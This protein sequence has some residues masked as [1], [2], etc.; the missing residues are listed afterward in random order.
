MKVSE[1][2]FKEVM[3]QTAS[4]VVVI[5]T[6][7]AGEMYGFTANSFTSLSLSPALVLFC[8]NNKS[9]SIDALR[10]SRKFGVSILS[11]EQEE[12]SRRFAGHNIDKFADIDYY[13]GIE[14][15]CPLIVNSVGSIECTIENEYDGGDHTIFIGLAREAT[16]NNDLDPIIYHSGAYKRIAK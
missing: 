3:R 14:T 16:V 2:K 8:I 15:G 9:R 12:I 13:N 10:K 7:D 11:C 1:A 6:I 4:G 5:S